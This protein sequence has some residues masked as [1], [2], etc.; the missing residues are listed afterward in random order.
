MPGGPCGYASAEEHYNALLEDA[1][2]RD[3]PTEHSLFSLSDWSGH[4]GTDNN[5]G[6]IAILGINVNREGTAVRLNPEAQAVFLSDLQ[7]WDE[8]QAIDPI[9]FWDDDVLTI[10]TKGIKE[11]LDPP[12]AEWQQT[13][14]LY[15]PRLFTTQ[16]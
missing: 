8:D 4:W 14:L 15:N 13:R 12:V 5:V 2:S 9:G 3:G 7:R 1:R 6:E 10:W 16:H 11:G